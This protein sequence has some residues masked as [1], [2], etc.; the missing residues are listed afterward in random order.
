VSS[1]YI[2]SCQQCKTFLLL[3]VT[4]V[5]GSG[6]FF[7]II[8]L[9]VHFSWGGGGGEKYLTWNVFLDAFA[10]L[11]KATVTFV[12]PVRTSIKNNSSPTE[13]IFIK[14]DI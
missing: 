2:G 12:M 10:K 6:V 4:Y 8:S 9:T 14:F 7:V 11:R 5:S 3:H 13:K 1:R